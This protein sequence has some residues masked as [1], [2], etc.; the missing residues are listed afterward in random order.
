MWLP[1]EAF[2]EDSVTFLQPSPDVTLTEPANASEVIT[3]STYDSYTD[4]W[5]APSGR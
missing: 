3:I 5:Y 4:S 1:I 2:L